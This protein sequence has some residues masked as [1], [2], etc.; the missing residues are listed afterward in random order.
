LA[1]VRLSIAELESLSVRETVPA[2]NELPS[3]DVVPE[4][5]DQV[6][7]PA[8]APIRPT[9]TAV[10][11]TFVAVVVGRVMILLLD[12]FVSAPRFGARLLS[13]STAVRLFFRRLKEDD[14]ADAGHP[15]V[16]RGR[17]DHQADTRP[18]AG[19]QPPAGAHR[20]RDVE[21]VQ[22]ERLPQTALGKRAAETVA[23][24]HP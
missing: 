11:M 19:G 22:Q 24:E 15:A 3:L 10:A 6:P 18:A 4:K 21:P 16:P 9:T 17:G 8:T 20:D 13:S 14:P 1:A 5:A 2:A 7:T 12:E 23:T